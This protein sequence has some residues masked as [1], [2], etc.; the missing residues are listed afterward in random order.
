MRI[1][2]LHQYFNTPEMGGATRS[3]EMGR[4]LAHAGHDVQVITADCAGGARQWRIDSL[5]GMTVHWAP[6]A[7]DNRMGYLRR[8]RAFLAFAVMARRRA[9]EIG[10]DVI[11]ATST[12]L[13]IALPAVGAARKLKRPM[14]LEVR[15]LWPA[16]PIA[17]GVLKD[18][19]SRAFARWLERFAYRNASRIVALAPGMRDEIIATGYP[20]NRVA[21]IPN[22]ADLDVFAV[23]SAQTK[24]LRSDNVWLEERPLVVYAGTIG[25]VHHLDYLVHLAAAVHRLDPEIRF[26]IIGTGKQEEHVRQLATT[27]GVLGVNLYMLGQ[28]PKH[29]VAVWLSACT[30]ATALASGP[31]IVWKDATNNKFFDALAAGRPVVSNLPGWSALVAEE[32]GAGFTVPFDD[33]AS[34]AETLVAKLRDQEWLSA[35]GAAALNLARTRFD[36]DMLALELESVLRDAV[37]G[38][39]T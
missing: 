39:G 12:P 18:P 38:D 10:G 26:A 3:Y 35:A 4:R 25:R 37:G 28:A 24:A 23:A 20:A 17:L 13:T 16:V 1:L 36:R 15:D 31:R 2:Y 7:Y 6:V 34:A 21:V 9:V 22:G 19:I 8:I 27:L 11:F 29:V 33:L 5:E 30:V 32:A 14:V